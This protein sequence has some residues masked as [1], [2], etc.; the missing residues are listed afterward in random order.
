[1]R[2]APITERLA[3]TGAAKWAIHH[4]ARALQN[5]GL[6]LIEL[7][8]GEPDLPPEPA[9]FDVAYQ[10]MK[11]GRTR[12][13][14]GRGEPGLLDA[15]AKRYLKRRLGITPNHIMCFP[16]TQ[17]GL[18]AT[19][20]GLAGE[21]DEVLVGDPSYAT[22]EGIIRSSG[23]K[24]V[25][26]LLRPEH[27]FQMQA[28]DLEAAVTPRSRV[29]LL[30]S[31]HNP[32]G[33]VMTKAEIEAIGEICIK[34]DL[35]IVCDE[36][37]EE[38]VFDGEFASPFDLPHLAERVVAVSSISKMLAAPGFRSGWVVGPEDFCDRLL[39]LSESMLFGNQPFIAD[40]T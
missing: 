31:P 2:F 29:V 35:W 4:R 36:V 18:F 28:A 15:L 21:G 13:S 23:A 9:L 3:D 17:T 32:T 5:Q 40:M 19:I 7:T 12:Y 30:N 37:Y 33:A 1:M 38:L 25:S 16:G 39:P 26:V 27:G 34:H 20:M 6:D 22:Y 10:A 14:S 8:I 24:R 11:L